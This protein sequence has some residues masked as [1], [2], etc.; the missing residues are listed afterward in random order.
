MG[1]FSPIVVGT[2]GPYNLEMCDLEF[3][4]VFWN[5]CID[6]DIC[7]RIYNVYHM[8]SIFLGVRLQRQRRHNLFL[9]KLPTGGGF[10]IR[11]I[12]L[13]SLPGYSWLILVSLA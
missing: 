11:M 7:S 12:I 2:L 3:W 9:Q 13:P 1:L 10:I 8:S 4:D 5:Y 6:D